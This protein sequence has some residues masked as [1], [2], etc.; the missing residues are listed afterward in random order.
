[1]TESLVKKWRWPWTHAL[2][3]VEP[4]VVGAMNPRSE[5]AKRGW[6]TRRYRAF[7]DGQRPLPF[8]HGVD[9]KPKKR[10]ETPK[11]CPEK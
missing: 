8:R 7:E 4:R 9:G 11:P 10:K 1:M 6:A 2:D 3:V 5:A